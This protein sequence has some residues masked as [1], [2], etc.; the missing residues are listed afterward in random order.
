M[1]TVSLFIHPHVVPNLYNF[2]SSME[3]KRR[4]FEECFNCFCP[5]SS[6]V[7]H[8]RKRV[9]FGMTL[10]GVNDDRIFIFG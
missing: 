7:F 5:K 1:K 2:H 3:L 9:W 4:Y 8:G 10:W 6:F